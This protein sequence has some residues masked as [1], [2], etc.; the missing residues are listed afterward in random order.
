MTPADRFP[1]GGRRAA[2]EA[3]RSGAAETVLVATN[4]RSTPG[5]REVLDAG[6]RSG[7][8]VRRVPAQ[9]LDALGAHDHQGV[10]TLLRRPRELDD[11]GL[12]GFHFADDALVVLLDGIEDPQNLGACARSAEAAGATMVIVRERRSAGLSPG[13]IRASAG[14]LLHLP[15]ARVT[16]LSRTLDALRERGSVAVGLDHRAS[17]TIHEVDPPPRPLVLVL[18]AEGTGISRLVRE[19]CDLLVRIPTPGRVGSLNASAALAAALFGF[20][21]RP[22]AT[23]T[24]A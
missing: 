4:L 13:A 20:V 19:R 3:I 23:E 8:A 6:E 14:A 2:L 17:H 21:L 5:L 18:G 12:A 22:S 16:N 1:L 7:I 24:E 9:E 10:V 11:R 15:L